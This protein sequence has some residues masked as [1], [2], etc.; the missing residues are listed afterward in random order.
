MLSAKLLGSSGLSTLLPEALAGFA[1]VALLYYLV[2]RAFGAG[3]GLLAA[4]MLAV[5]PVSVVTSRNNTI[6][7]LLVLTVLL[8]AWTASLATERGSLRW[9]LATAAIV[10]LGFAI[11]MM[12]AYLV[13]PALFLLYLTA[14][15]RKLLV[16]IGH[17]ALAAIVLV[18]V[19]FA[20]PVTVDLTPKDQRPY[21]GSSQ[22]NSAV[23]LA[24]GYNG[25]QRLFGRGFEVQ[26][27]LQ[28]LGALRQLGRDGGGGPGGFGETG[29]PGPLRLLD[30]QLAGQDSWLLP[31]AG[32][33]IVA[34]AVVAWSQ[35]RRLASSRR[36]QALFLWGT[37][38]ATTGVFFSVAGYFHRYYM[39]MMAPSVAALAA[40]G[41]WGGW[42]AYQRWRWLA[43]ILPAVLLGTA[44]L[45]L[46]ILASY[47][48]WSTWM[49]PV[50]LSSAALAAVLLLALRPGLHT[51]RLGPR[52]T[53]AARGAAG[54]GG[55][56]LLMAPTV[57]GGLPTLDASHQGGLPSAGPPPARGGFIPFGFVAPQRGADGARGP[58]PSSTN[59][60]EHYLEANQG[61]A[62]YL[63]A[64]TN[65][66]TAAP[67]ILATGKPVMAMGGFIG[68]DP[69]LTVDQLTAMVHRGDVRFF[70]L[71]GGFGGR[72]GA[73]GSWV[74]NNCASVPS[75]AL[76]GN[77]AS[78][79]GRFGSEGNPFQGQLY[80]CGSLEEPNT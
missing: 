4:L 10:G 74:Q 73:L 50:A 3:T 29:V 5:T 28:P 59:A 40:I 2:S 30:Q 60:L 31:L 64:T 67:L 56:G 61:T 62:R 27:G 37:W 70:E 32:L 80:D 47:P 45:Q 11:K 36:A 17:L 24:L 43:W 53:L 49:T 76:E 8:A 48:E 38:L 35:R 69:I 34:S 6:D 9:L 65:A 16:R 39:V 42:L 78:P 72:G 13:V 25:L 75:S 12:E 7:T 14:G 52:L 46:H 1:A 54:L 58:V 68:S 44:V 71:G 15:R 20:W 33:G 41:L 21:V 51:T 26:P 22:D 55:L 57:W 23:S 18:A 66:N 19:S 77:G 63:V 79:L